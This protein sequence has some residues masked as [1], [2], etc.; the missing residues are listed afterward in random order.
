MNALGLAEED[1]GEFNYKLGGCV[2]F[3][4]PKLESLR[5]M[6]TYNSYLHHLYYFSETATVWFIHCN[7]PE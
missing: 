5:R 6:P 4:S 1:S 7:G 2:I 3:S